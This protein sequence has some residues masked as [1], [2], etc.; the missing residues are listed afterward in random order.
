MSNSIER[1]SLNEKNQYHAIDYANDTRRFC[2]AGTEPYI[3]I[4]DEIKMKKVQ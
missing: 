1:I 2:V 3:E 4:Y